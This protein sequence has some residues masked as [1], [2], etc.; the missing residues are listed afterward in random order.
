MSNPFLAVSQAFDTFA[1]LY[2]LYESGSFV[3]FFADGETTGNMVSHGKEWS[4]N[5]Q[6]L[7]SSQPSEEPTK[8]GRTLRNSPLGVP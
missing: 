2:R 8:I 3:A 1:D 5:P 6:R 7:G 4:G